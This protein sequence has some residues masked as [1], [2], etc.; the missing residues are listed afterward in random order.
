[1][2][3]ERNHPDA[4]P[5]QSVSNTQTV[6]PLRRLLA[7]SGHSIDDVINCPYA[8]GNVIGYFKL[9]KAMSRQMEIADLE[10]QWN[11]HRLLG[12]TA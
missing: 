3:F 4:S 12:T 1:M 2:Q 11:R 8:R 7:F 5:D 6:N 9:G 10:R